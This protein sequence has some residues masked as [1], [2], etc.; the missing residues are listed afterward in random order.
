MQDMIL[1]RMWADHHRRIYGEKSRP[2]RAANTPS[3]ALRAT[4]AAPLA[5]KMLAG[6]LALA[7]SYAT[8]GA[9]V[10]LV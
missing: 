3:T 1:S 2:Q 4:D 6:G 9:S 5:G 10:S 7:M 8:V